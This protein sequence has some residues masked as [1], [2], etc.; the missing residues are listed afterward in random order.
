M[1]CIGCFKEFKGNESAYATVVW[2]V[3][4]DFLTDDNL[5]FYIDDME[6][7][8]SV[9][10]KDCGMAVHDFIAYQLQLKHLQKPKKISPKD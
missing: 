7:W 3:E 6:P 5:D 1:K 4:K 2:G 9:L 8:L 10:C